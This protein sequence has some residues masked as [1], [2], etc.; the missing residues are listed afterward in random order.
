MAVNLWADARPLGL[1][2]VVL[3]ILFFVLGVVLVVDGRRRLAVA[4]MG[5]SAWERYRLLGWLNEFFAAYLRL[6][7]AWLPAWGRQ[8]PDILLELFYGLAF[9]VAGLGA[10]LFFPR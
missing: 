9:C 5:E 10:M 1:H 3:G 2:P 8:R 7:R 4:G 6:F